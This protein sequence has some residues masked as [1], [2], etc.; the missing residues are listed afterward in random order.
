[1]KSFVRIFHFLGTYL[2]RV[3][4]IIM[5][6][7]FLY[8]VG[9]KLG[10]VVAILGSREEGDSPYTK[11][12]RRNHI[13]L[14]GQYTAEDLFVFIKILYSDPVS[15]EYNLVIYGPRLHMTSS[16][17]Y[18]MMESEFVRGRVSYV[19]GEVGDTSG[20]S[21]VCLSSASSVF[22]LSTNNGGDP[23][24][25]D[26]QNAI[27]IG[28]IRSARPEIPSFMHYSRTE[29]TKNLE[30]RVYCAAV[31][32]QHAESIYRELEEMHE[33][34]IPRLEQ[35]LPGVHRL[36]NRK[37]LFASCRGTGDQSETEVSV[38]HKD[39]S[40]E[41]QNTRIYSVAMILLSVRARGATTLLTNILFEPE[42]P[43]V[44]RNK[45]SFLQ[46]D[47]SDTVPWI[48]E[49]LDGADSSFFIWLLPVEAEGFSYGTIAALAFE[50][51]G[52]SVVG[53]FSTLE[54]AV[55]AGDRSAQFEDRIRLFEFDAVPRRNET[56]LVI[57]SSY[58]ET[59][60]SSNE[61]HFIAALK[62][63]GPS[64]KQKVDGDSSS[65]TLIGRR[66]SVFDSQENGA[67][68]VRAKTTNQLDFYQ[69]LDAVEHPD[70]L[71]S[72]S[73]VFSTKD[74]FDIEGHLIIALES[75]ALFGELMLLLEIMHGEYL[76]ARDRIPKLAC[77]FVPN[78]QILVLA[79]DL[80][81]HQISTLR[82]AYRQILVKAGTARSLDDLI[83]VNCGAASSVV[84]LNEPDDSDETEEIGVFTNV[85]KDVTAFNAFARLNLNTIAGDLPSVNVTTILD[86]SRDLEHFPRTQSSAMVLRLG[87]PASS[88]LVQPMAGIFERPT[89]RATTDQEKDLTIGLNSVKSTRAD[90]D[91]LLYRP[92]YAAGE[93]I[94]KSALTA[95]LGREFH[96]P[97]ISDF[98]GTLL[99]IASTEG[100]SP[101][102]SLTVPAKFD[103]HT[104]V[105][106][107]GELFKHH[108]IPLGLFRSGKA[109]VLVG[110]KGRELPSPLED[111]KFIA[112]WVYANPKS[113]TVLS[114]FDAV[115][116]LACRDAHVRT[117]YESDEFKDELLAEDSFWNHQP[118][119]KSN[120][121]VATEFSDFNEFESVKNIDKEVEQTASTHL[122]TTLVT[123][124][125]SGAEA[126][127][128][129]PESL[130]VSDRVLI[131]EQ[132]CSVVPTPATDGDK[133]LQFE[134]PVSAKSLEANTE[135]LQDVGTADFYDVNQS[136]CV[137][138][139]DE[140]PE[141]TASSHLES[142]LVTAAASGAEAYELAPESLFV[143]DNVLI[144]DHSGS[145]VPTHATD[146]DETRQLV[147]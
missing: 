123:A 46:Q 85:A 77:F 7:F 57:C 129:A 115:F 144:T 18:R 67:M 58:A 41:I 5:L 10:E 117:L 32:V 26:V 73:I 137:K 113:H 24:A 13:L 136:E 108:L 141:Q 48:E 11:A 98:I 83:S 138:Q 90:I 105:E 130:F 116:V 69:L 94:P 101:I 65:S 87:L 112:P 6:T 124:A 122:E 72:S 147:D 111:N 133:S 75:R 19:S 80:T 27:N 51:L 145:V 40:G 78:P 100:I 17:W 55:E 60:Y 71:A 74:Y 23:I 38:K 28:A 89:M 121:E 61:H 25:R 96:I 33:H 97:G 103:G 36:R 76:S 146:V 88:S 125:A 84:L 135:K 120:F 70:S 37:S 2:G 1:M 92:C 34:S 39:G 12:N 140:G 62:E 49:F 99:G 42:L 79:P 127:E 118:K 21:R 110:E 44:A 114:K 52:F 134:A 15:E 54:E 4:L 20:Y 63:Q 9:A 29:L 93:M 22:I 14:S 3:L 30:S 91:P 86:D 16:E 132:P 128:S 126:Y 139:E 109:P 31:D 131:T 102:I 43:S 53:A 59:Y 47:F 95:L 104:Y 35:V 107:A 56:L 106:L 8:Y 68:T 81:R 50:K 82:K 143:S 66:G 142:T 45:E 64:S 119:S